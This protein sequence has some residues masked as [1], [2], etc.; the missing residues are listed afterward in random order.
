[1]KISVITATRNC[2]STLPGTILSIESQTHNSI[3]AIWIDCLST[4]GTLEYLK[5]KLKSQSSILISESDNGIYDALNKGLRL[6]TG[7]IIG[8]LHSDDIYADRFCLS[9][10]AKAFEDTQVDAVY[11]DLVYVNKYNVDS[12]VRYWRS[13][14]FKNSL[15]KQ[16]WMP[17]HPTLYVRRNIYEN[18]GGFNTKF[19][20]SSD[21]D[22]VLR[23]FSNPSFKSKYLPHILVKMRT[24]GASNKSITNIL[25]KSIEDMQVLKK[26]KVGGGFTLFLKNF[27]KIP[28]F[29][30]DGNPPAK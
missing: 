27:S 28:Q 8:F 6:A 7:D 23:L 19:K 1:M 13:K 3:E 30:Q 25:K 4:D 15:L 21:Y 29:F 14:E 16:G 17:P 20:I 24:G 18:L 12:K 26:H 11:G 10:I 22:L 2:I 5:S 9:R